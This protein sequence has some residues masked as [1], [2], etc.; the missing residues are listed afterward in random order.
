M[1][2]SCGALRVTDN[3]LGR[4]SLLDARVWHSLRCCG[5]LHAWPS[6]NGCAA[7]G[8]ESA[9]PAMNCPLMIFAMRLLH[10]RTNTPSCFCGAIPCREEIVER[11][12]AAGQGTWSWSLMLCWACASVES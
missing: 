11:Y 1:P 2:V 4:G 12:V 10:V 7:C 6:I 5:A 3:L 9:A 8:G